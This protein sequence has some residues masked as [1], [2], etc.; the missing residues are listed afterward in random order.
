MDAG[1]AVELAK[2]G[3]TLL[4]LDVPQHTLIGIDTHMVSVGPAFKGIKMIP[5]GP[6]FLYYSSSTR[7]S[8]TAAR[9]PQLLTEIFCHGLEYPSDSAAPCGVIS[10]FSRKAWKT[11]IKE[12]DCLWTG[13]E[14]EKDD[15][16]DKRGHLEEEIQKVKQQA[17]EHS[18][19]IDAD[20]SDELTSVWSG[21]DEEKSLWTGSE[22]DDDDDILLK[23][24]QMR[25]VTNT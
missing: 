19:L 1:T 10:K 13:S 6:H 7:N 21:S 11:E 3:S 14:D 12:D 9:C 15:G 5:P 4:L 25:A 24:T 22:G 18:D 23:P 2:Q 8:F 16:K 17:R 20:D